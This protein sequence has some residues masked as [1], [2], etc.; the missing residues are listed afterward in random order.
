VQQ[1]I[2]RPFF[3]RCEEPFIA[4]I[5]Y[6]P[7]SDS[8]AFTRVFRER[9]TA[10]GIICAAGDGKS[11][12]KF[13]PVNFLGFTE[14]FA[15]GMASLARLSGAPILPVFCIQDGEGKRTLIIENPIY[16]KGKDDREHE[17]KNSLRHYACLLEA[18][19]NRFP[20][21]YRNWHMLGESSV[22]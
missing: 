20:H 22:S 4:G 7:D 3:E 13:V 2:I 6:L 21:L 19:I 9:L 12:Q 10:N 1:K 17:L 5:L 18:Y 11:G 15:T 8:L 14:P 16:L